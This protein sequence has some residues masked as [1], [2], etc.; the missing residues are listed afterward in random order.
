MNFVL[1]CPTYTTLLILSLLS[2]YFVLD[3]VGLCRTGFLIEIGVSYKVLLKNYK[4]GFFSN[5]VGLLKY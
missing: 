2:V 4:K 1:H 3:A 5:C